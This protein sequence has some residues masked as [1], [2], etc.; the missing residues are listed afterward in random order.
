MS[1]LGG[2]GEGGGG[3]V[4][5][6]SRAQNSG[7]I[8][9]QY[10]VGSRVSGLLAPPPTTSWPCFLPATLLPCIILGLGFSPCHPPGLEELH[11]RGPKAIIVDEQHRL[12]GGPG[13]ASVSWGCETKGGRKQQQVAHRQPSMQQRPAWRKWVLQH[14]PLGSG[15]RA[16]AAE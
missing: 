12:Q 16:C 2:W 4:G 10:A 9:V 11:E 14:A 7:T 8:T 6:H 1:L 3:E 5:A 13:W 15:C